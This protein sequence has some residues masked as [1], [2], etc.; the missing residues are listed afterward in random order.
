[1]KRIVIITAMFIILTGLAGCSSTQGTAPV[2]STQPAQ[3]ATA[4]TAGEPSPTP[5]DTQPTDTTPTPTDDLSDSGNQDITEQTPWPEPTSVDYQGSYLDV[6]QD[7][8]ASQYPTL[9]VNQEEQ[10]FYGTMKIPA[11]WS[12]DDPEGTTPAIID[13]KGRIVVQIY[14]VS[15]YISQPYYS[16]KPDSGILMTW[17][18]TDKFQYDARIMALESD[19][20]T[21]SGESRK[22]VIK[23]VS[24]LSGDAYADEDGSEYYL[25]FCLS[26][27]KA[28]IDGGN[29][30]YVISNKTIDEIVQSFTNGLNM[31]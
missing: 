19:Y 9:K 31:E 5:S 28:Y 7:K 14:Q 12:I 21:A 1:M 23:I 11:K 8:D 27:D 20:T 22:A 13:A 10:T 24:L 3:T 29:V 2:G 6:A 4:S 30:D 26:F 15:A 17:E 16:L 18:A 25:A